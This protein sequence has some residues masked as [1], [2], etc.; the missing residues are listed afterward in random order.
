MTETE[1]AKCRRAFDQFDINDDGEIDIEELRKVFKT[2]GEDLSKEE[3]L[4]MVLN[5][6]YFRS[7][8][9]LR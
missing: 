4:K 1:Y 7:H 8:N 9:L 2:L 3:I 6:P 5:V